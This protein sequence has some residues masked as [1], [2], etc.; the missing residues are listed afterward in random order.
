M[1]VFGNNL[2]INKDSATSGY[3]AIRCAFQEH[4]AVVFFPLGALDFGVH[5][6]DK[7]VELDIRTKRNYSI[8][9]INTFHHRVLFANACQSVFIA[10]RNEKGL[11]E[12]NQTGL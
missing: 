6:S 7:E 1:L 10:F 11:Y 9:S 4:T 5:I 12:L 2:S 3:N 8:Y